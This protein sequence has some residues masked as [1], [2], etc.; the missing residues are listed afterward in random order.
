M[1]HFFNILEG[2]NLFCLLGIEEV[3]FFYYIKI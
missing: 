3:Q 1:E 2:V